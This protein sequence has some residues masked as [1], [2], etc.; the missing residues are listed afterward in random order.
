VADLP[1]GGWALAVAA[2][3]VPLLLG[4]AGKA[5]GLGRVD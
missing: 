4:Q 5:A 1:A 3:L 2:A